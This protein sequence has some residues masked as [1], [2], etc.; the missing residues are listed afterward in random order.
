M[1]P[2]ELAR[3]AKSFGLRRLIVTDTHRD[4]EGKGINLEL[5]SRF[6]TETGL[7][8]IAAGG[9]KAIEDVRQSKNAGLAGVV[10]GRALYE[11]QLSL[12]EALSC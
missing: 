6:Q 4:G 8:V 5:C 2:L 12:Q 11:G 1:D 10:L 3:Q 7:N 9:A